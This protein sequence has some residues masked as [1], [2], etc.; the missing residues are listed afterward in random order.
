MGSEEPNTF[1]LQQAAGPSDDIHDDAADAA[2]L[3]EASHE[4]DRS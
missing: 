1:G 3:R 4:H 2:F